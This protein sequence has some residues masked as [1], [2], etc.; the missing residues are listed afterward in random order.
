MKKSVPLFFYIKVGFFMDTFF[1]WLRK[2]K[3]VQAGYDQ[4]MAQS[5]R[6]SHTKNRGRGGKKLNWLLGTY[7]KKTQ[8]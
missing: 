2:D 8:S 4:E 1:F 3:N 7:T 6:N 5:E